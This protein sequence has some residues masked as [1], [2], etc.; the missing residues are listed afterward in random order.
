ME[1]TGHRLTVVRAD[2][3]RIRR[4]RIQPLEKGEA[5]AEQTE[6]EKIEGP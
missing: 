6:A 2:P 1:I 4:I 5:K 3:T